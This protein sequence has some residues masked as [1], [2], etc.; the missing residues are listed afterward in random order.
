[1]LDRIDK[2]DRIS[3]AGAVVLLLGLFMPWYGIDAGDI[4]DG[5]GADLARALVE[6][7]SVNAFEAFDFI[8]I[9]L[10]VLAIGAAALIVLVAL[11]KV[12]ESYKKFVETIGGAAVIAVVFR[13]IIQ[14]DFASLKWG[15]FV[16]LIG[17]VGIAAGQFLTRTGKI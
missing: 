4:G 7:V 10:L 12:D 16:A 17:A 9:V 15:I 11:G 13:I 3:L 8:D 14:P 5:P 6:S 1:M 2:G